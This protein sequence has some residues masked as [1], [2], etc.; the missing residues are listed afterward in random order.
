[1]KSIKSFSNWLTHRYQLVI[2]NK[3]DLAEK[4][5]FSF[6]YGRLMVLLSTLM[7][8]L[9][10]CSLWLAST[11][12]SQWFNPIH[13]E[14]ENKKEILQL[15]AAVDALE[16]QT[17]QQKKFI[18][19]LQSIIAGKESPAYELPKVE[20]RPTAE[21]KAALADE[22]ELLTKDMSLQPGWENSAVATPAAHYKPVKD[23]QALFFFPPITGIVTTPFQQKIGH[24]GVDIVARENEPIKSVADGVVVLAAWTVETGWVIVVQHNKDLVSIYKHNAAL[25]K[26][27]GNFVKAGDVIAVMGNSGELSTGPHLH[28][29]LWYE[30]KAVNPEHF[31]TF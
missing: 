31:I 18:A 13:I 29:E 10:A 30:G 6:S 17:T 19:L 27:V 16:E 28:F 3:E 2:R 14:Q 7:A 8:V 22:P 26:K 1:M 20:E 15:S 23:L 25:L 9:L 11:I 5:A 4:S 21:D 24:Y 12:L